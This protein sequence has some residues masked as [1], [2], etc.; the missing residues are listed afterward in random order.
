MCALR[1]DE[2]T[3]LTTLWADCLGDWSKVWCPDQCCDQCFGDESDFI[4]Y[5]GYTDADTGFPKEHT[6]PPVAAA[7]IPGRTFLPTASPIASE[8]TYASLAEN[9]ALKTDLISRMT[10]FEGRL[11][12]PDSDAYKAYL[13]LA[14]APDFAELGEFRKLQ[15]FGLSTFYLSTQSQLGWKVS[16][17]WQT[18]EHE[19]NW[20]GISCAQEDTVT[21]ISLP[22]NRLSGTIPPEIGLAGLGGEIGKLNLSGNN[23]GGKLAEQLGTLKHLEVLDL[24]SNDFTGKIP[25]TLGQL[26][27]L[28]SLQIQANE[29]SGVMPRSICSLVAAGDVEV[30][31]DCDVD[32]PFSRVECELGTCCSQ[33]Y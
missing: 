32:D 1:S 16:N 24:R 31:A 20:F 2:K 23:I 30:V 7:V 5:G 12:D 29:L 4:P 21:E 14:N 27:R 22:S 28:T 19:C 33:C 10:G 11:S 6:V 8:P 3:G 13:W 18:T 26:S 17:N 25:A 9:E 15:R